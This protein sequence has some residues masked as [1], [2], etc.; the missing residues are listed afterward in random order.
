MIPGTGGLIPGTTTI[1]GTGGLVV[2][3]L[4]SLELGEQTFRLIC[5]ATMLS[6]A[7]QPTTT[8]KQGSNY[9][10]FKIRRSKWL[11]PHVG[12]D[13]WL[14]IRVNWLPDEAIQVVFL[15]RSPNL[16]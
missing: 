13:L 1:P 6:L 7:V 12:R 9:Q 4:S 16:L 11:I 14:R 10:R 15:W 2:A 3:I 5:R 8:N